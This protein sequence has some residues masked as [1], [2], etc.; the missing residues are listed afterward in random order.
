MSKKDQITS[1]F[2]LGISGIEELSTLTKS[3]PS[4]V[5]NVLRDSRL[6]SGYFDLYTST[7]RPMN[8]YSKY[9]T[10]RLGFKNPTTA[11]QSVEYLNALYNQFA[12]I[13]DR[14]GQHH[15]LILALT[16][17]NRALWSNKAEE[18]HIYGQWLVKQLSTFDTPSPTARMHKLIKQ[19]QRSRS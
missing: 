3:S 7:E 6:L 12:R 18:A 10:K 9:F 17:R 2:Q 16:M 15:A 11:R 1:L 4:Y 14:A 13:E 5:S 19:K 8:V